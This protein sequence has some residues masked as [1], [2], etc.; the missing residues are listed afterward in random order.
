MT[1]PSP[2]QSTAKANAA[3]DFIDRETYTVK[4]SKTQ[5]PLVALL[6]A[7]SALALS[8]CSTFSP[9]PLKA[10]PVAGER[11][12]PVFAEPLVKSADQLAPRDLAT[13]IFLRPGSSTASAKDAPLNVYVNGRYLASLLPGGY[14]EHRNCAGAVPVAAVFDDARIRHLGQRG[15]EANVN[16]EAGR[17]YY[18]KVEPAGAEKQAKLTALTVDQVFLGEYRR[19]S[20]AVT[21]APAC[22]PG[23]AAPSAAVAPAIVTA[24]VLAAAAP[25]VAAA[26]SAAVAAEQVR[27]PLEGWRAAWERGDYE[28]YKSFYAP[29]FKGTLASR[30][31][32][33]SQRRARLNNE[34]KQIALDNVVVGTTSS[35]VTTD[36]RQSY[37]SRGF[38]DN[39]QKRLVWK[40][41]AG[42]LK[43]VSE[44]FSAR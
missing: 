8:A 26:P 25:A 18:F 17:T 22:L 3:P 28:A 40:T 15:Q 23:A 1:T 14:V 21:R 24:P 41:V 5:T 38:T 12:N 11:G 33:E 37:Q 31:A 35:S 10:G 6:P 16:I 13:L 27:A 44:T 34:A 36:F 43:I 32:W 9:D 29:D 2:C 30:K 20:H 7:L 42:E 39:G 19:Q 4:N